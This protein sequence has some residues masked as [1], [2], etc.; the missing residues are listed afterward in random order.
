VEK[1]LTVED[2]AERL[3]VHPETVRRWLREGW[4]TGYRIS[5]RGGW[6]IR[7]A[8]VEAMLAEMQPEGKLAA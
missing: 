1:L 3:Q 4:L 7:P 6:R 8:S 5:R 2:V